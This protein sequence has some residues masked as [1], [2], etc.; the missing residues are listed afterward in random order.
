[1]LTTAT[2]EVI[3]AARS[4]IAALDLTFR[5]PLAKAK[6]FPIDHP[7]VLLISVLMVATKICFPLTFAQSPL[8]EDNITSIPRLDWQAWGQVISQ[9]PGR[10]QPSSSKLDI[11]SITPEQVV[12]MTDSELDE[13]FSRV[14][15]LNDK[16]ST[17][18]NA[19]QGRM[20]TNSAQI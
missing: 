20:W 18:C 15:S 5:F 17:W 12:S 1:M 4:L 3:R 2:V 14:A 8:S 11:D 6:I 16:K 10:D 9:A 13:Y 7:E 19:V